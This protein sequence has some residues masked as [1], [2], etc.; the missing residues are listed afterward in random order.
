MSEYH[1]RL[2]TDTVKW[3]QKTATIW[4]EIPNKCLDEFRI[5][6][7]HIARLVELVRT[8]LRPNNPQ[9]GLWY[10]ERNPLPELVKA[11]RRPKAPRL[12]DQDG[13]Y[14]TWDSPVNLFLDEQDRGEKE[15]YLPPTLNL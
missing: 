11:P 9:C 12:F 4:I 15:H 8:N 6:Q 2:F 1:I 14:H 7:T 5:M 13:N 10:A 3:N